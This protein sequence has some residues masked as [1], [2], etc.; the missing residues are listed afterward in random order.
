MGHASLTWAFAAAAALFRRHNP[1]AQQ[2][3]AKLETKHG[4]GNALTLLAPK[5]AR[6]VYD[7][8]KRDT[9]VDM[10]LFLPG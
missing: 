4:K 7:M 6:A 8:L 10:D 3:V 5:L 1:Q 9:V 2:Y